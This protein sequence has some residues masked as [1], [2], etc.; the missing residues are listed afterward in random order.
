[1]LRRPRN[2]FGIILGLV[3]ELSLAGCSLARPLTH[4]ANTIQGRVMD[5]ETGKPVVGAAVVAT[6]TMYVWVGVPPYVDSRP[7]RLYVIETVTDTTGVYTIPSWGPSLLP[8][9][10]EVSRGSPQLRVFKRGYRP[11]SVSNKWAGRKHGGPTSDWDGKVIQLE[12]PRGSL[13]EQ[14]SRLSGVYDGLGGSAF[15]EN[16]KDGDDWKNYPCATLEVLRERERLVALGVNPNYGGGVP[17]MELFTKDDQEFLRSLGHGSRGG[18]R[19][20]C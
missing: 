20:G 5:A 9:T 7:K 12:H 18:G 3:L 1:M 10:A 2:W 11:H 15:I 14:A 4:S 17:R 6:W 13:K 8:L 19:A 16:W